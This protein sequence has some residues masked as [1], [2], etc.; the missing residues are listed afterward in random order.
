MPREKRQ[1]KNVSS[2]HADVLSF[3]ETFFELFCIQNIPKSRQRLQHQFVH[4][5]LNYLDDLPGPQNPDTDGIYE[6]TILKAQEDARQI[7]NLAKQHAEK[8]IEDA[9]R[10]G[11]SLA[12]PLQKIRATL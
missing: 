3:N 9:E 10:R 8:I 7:I 2:E 4:C 5:Y 1:S 11:G 12:T 6:S